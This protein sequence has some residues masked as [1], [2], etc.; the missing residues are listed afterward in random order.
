MGWIVEAAYR[1]AGGRIVREQR[2]WQG[3]ALVA[4]SVMTFAGP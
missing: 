1:A 4:E 3:S 2:V